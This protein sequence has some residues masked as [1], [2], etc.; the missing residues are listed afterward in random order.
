MTENFNILV[1][2]LN[3]FKTKFYFYKLLRGIII[4][5]LVLLLVYTVFSIVEYY[6]FLNRNIRT[7]VFFGFIVFGVLLFVQFI[8]VPLLKIAR[9]LTPI[10][11]KSAARLIQKHF[12]EINDKLINIIELA[13][14]DEDRYS[15]EIVQA[16]IDQK[17]RQLKVF[18][19]NE[20]V[21]FKNIKKVGIYLIISVISAF[22][23]FLLNSNI[24]TDSTKRLV[25]YNQQFEKPAPFIF[26][27]K[28][29]VLKAKKG[30]A[31]KFLLITRGDE[32]PKL[33]YINI[34]G[35]NYLMKS[36]GDGNFEYEMA[37][38]INPVQFYFTD[39][40]FNS[41]TFFL[42]LIPK[43]GLNDFSC[44][45][46]PPK[47]TGLPSQEFKNIGD[48]QIPAGTSVK[49]QFKGIDIDQLFIKLNDSTQFDAVLNDNFFEI[50]K[51]IYKS[52][53]YNVFIKNN[54]TENELALTFSIE[55]IPDLFPEIKV[56]QVEDS[57][58]L[59]RFYFKGVI[60]D[61]Y[62]FTGL[63]FH[64]NI[65]ESDSAI[66]I[67]FLRSLTDQE[68]Y[69]SFDFNE[70]KQNEG[71]ISYYF[72]VSDNDAVN[73]SK[74]T[75]S[76]SFVFTFPD[77]EEIAA[78][79]KEKFNQ[80]E[81]MLKDS[82]ELSKEIQIDLKNLQ[83]KNMDSN[84]SDWEKSQMV[85]DIISKQ[86]KLENLYEQIKQDNE[87]LN[88]YLNSFDKQNQ[89]MVEKQKQIEELLDEV[90]TDE[91]KKLMEEFNKL[92][93]DFDSKKLNQLSK[94]MDLSMEDLQKQLDR[95]LE[96]LRKMKI[97]QKIQNVIDELY[98]IANEQDSL[99]IKVTD[100][101][102]LDEV[103]SEVSENQKD[104]KQLENDL[105]DALELNN[106]LEKPLLFDDFDEDFDNVNSSFEES[107]SEIEKKNRK[108]A[109][110]SLK[111]TSENLQNLAFGMQQMLNANQKKNN[112]ENIANLKQILSNLIFM[113]FSQEDILNS[114]R[115]ISSKDPRLVQ[116]NKSQKKILDESLIVK[117]SLYA[118]AKRTPAI[119]GMVNNELL[120]MQMNLDK[121]TQQME[122]ALFP[123]ARVSQQFVITAVNNL[124]L[125]LN[126]ALENLEKQQA[127]AQPGDQECE[128]PGNG[129]PGMD[130]LKK[131]G[132]NIKQQLQQMIDQMKKGNPQNMSK[133]LG[134][135]LMEHEMMQQMLRDMINNGS[136]GSGTKK[137][138]QEI[139]NLLEQN[140]KE[141]MSKKIGA[142]T[143]SR[144]NLIT[145]RLLEAEKGE[146]ERDFDDKRESKT[147][148]E[149]YSN[150]L[151]FFKYNE[152][153]N[154]TIEYLNRNT[155]KL[156]NFY[157]K[158]YKEYLNNIEKN[159]E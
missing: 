74:T 23:L 100:K 93:Q 122:E 91:L 35:N 25:H 146:I 10:D 82:R 83:F 58:R 6:V 57:I 68:F 121:A 42:K 126:E 98:S 145:T 75:T 54:E 77:K 156:N 113:S 64:Y 92:A 124:A 51:N 4:T 159:G 52:T 80:L 24:Y 111:T 18:N 109:Q 50:E 87:N 70:L 2:K 48:L 63:N 38:V 107:K 104:I 103:G 55:V 123:N 108:K 101:Q 28:N 78:N 39:L 151:K 17:I 133:Q 13:N 130:L 148:K 79:D 53:S 73:G 106:K 95:N 147:A 45:I 67:P 44:A 76:D 158:K 136:V 114:L 149:F 59:S 153:D 85:N 3:S 49:W 27:L 141:L 26:S 152:N 112:S 143:L 37:S 20:A 81:N 140:R 40:K 47:Y 90:F 34:E 117:D 118:L 84:I 96:M 115:N 94:N 12:S 56:V 61:D 1:N 142:Q 89:E 30:D 97:E 15:N 9:I 7:I 137:K 31:F 129:K 135:S 19:F 139:D 125:M 66:T 150:P 33:V 120:A 16:S 21:Q 43:P 22:L 154:F 72:S 8:I 110:K 144:H 60:N 138:L 32:V 88:N 5:L 41:K 65:N 132:E 36:D 46:S 14:S 11:L 62:G 71:T 99:A 86:N 131:A 128:K 116:L 155:H 102:K 119:T 134:Q 29:T 127:N 105:N 69:F 157:T